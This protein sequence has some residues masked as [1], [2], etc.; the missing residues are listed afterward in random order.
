MDL[1]AIAASGSI[2]VA[3]PPEPLYD[4]IADMPSVGQISP[5]CL[6]GEWEGDDRGAGA[7]FVG[8]NAA[9]ERAWKAR[10]RVAVAERPREFAWENIGDGTKPAPDEIVPFAR[11]G[12]RFTPVDGGTLVEESWR[13]VTMYKELEAAGP[14]ILASLPTRMKASIDETLLR[15][16]ARFEA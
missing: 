8:S 13:L 6:G 1:S 5:Q 11:W 9:G 14:A 10:M 12:Y 2:V 4:F 15:L 7:F 3:V 16:K